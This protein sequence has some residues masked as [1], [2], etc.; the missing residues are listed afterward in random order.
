MGGSIKLSYNPGIINKPEKG[1]V[2]PYAEGFLPVE[3]DISQFVD[4]VKGG[5]AF[6]AQYKDN[7]RKTDNFICS[8]FVAV[9]IDHGLS[10]EDARNNQFLIE[11]ASFIY[12]TPS[13]TDL[14]NRFRIVFITPK[15][16]T[17]V[18]EWKKALQGVGR[19]FGG[20]PSIKDGAR[21]F[22][23]NTAA[24]IWRFNKTLSEGAYQEI[25][26]LAFSKMPSL[27]SGPA[28]SHSRSDAIDL[29]QLVTT[30]FGQVA[31]I[32]DLPRS[33]SIYCP[34]HIDNNP[35]AFITES[36][37][38]IKGVHCSACQTTYW[39]KKSIKNEVS[40][41]DELVKERLT[42]KIETNEIDP[43]GIGE[44]EKETVIRI[45]EK[46]L[47]DLSY[48]KGIT[49][50]K[51]PKGTGKTAALRSLVH[52]IKNLNRSKIL[53]HTPKSILLIGHRQAL[54]REACN[55]LGLTCYLDSLPTHYYG[56][57]LDS[58]GTKLHR[59]MGVPP[60][61]LVI[62]DESEQVF[63][64][65]VSDTI[66]Q[67]SNGLD[68]CFRHLKFYL[69]KAKAI[70]ALDADLDAITITALKALRKNDWE[71]ELRI[72]HN[73]WSVDVDNKRSIKM[74][75]NKGHL[76]K[77]MLSSIERGEKCYIA[78]NSKKM[79]D[80]LE[81]LVK[82]L[83]GS[84]YVKITSENS[85][86]EDIVE[87]VKTISVSAKKVDVILA[88]PSM[89]TGVDIT[90]PDN[91]IVFENVYG[92]FEPLVNT[93][94]DIDQQLARV[95]HPRDVKVFISQRKYYPE[96]DLNVIIENL[97]RAHVSPHAVTFT[98]DGQYKIDYDDP[99]LQIYAE[100]IA[101]RTSSSANIYEN[102]INHKK[103]SGYEIIYVSKNDRQ[104]DIGNQKLTGAKRERIA[105]EVE[106]FIQMPQ[107]SDEQFFGLYSKGLNAK[108]MKRDERILLEK[109]ITERALSIP[110]SRDIIK[111]ILEKR[112]IKKLEAFYF[113]QN[114][115][116]LSSTEHWASNYKVTSELQHQYLPLLRKDLFI[117]VVLVILGLLEEGVLNFRK[118]ITQQDL[119]R[120]AIFCETNRVI[121]GEITG[122]PARMDVKERTLMTLN[123]IL[124]EIGLA[125][126]KMKTQRQ[127]GS[128][129]HV[130][131][132]AP[133]LLARMERLA[134]HYTPITDA[135]VLQEAGCLSEYG[136]PDYKKF[137]SLFEF[138]YP[139]FLE[140]TASVKRV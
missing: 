33:T 91:E 111:E 1:A 40:A 49:L 121:I 34:I 77:E 4:L 20:D 66:M 45:S 126:R 110:L 61:D 129:S 101:Y 81:G 79:I 137:H 29:E 128:V 107:L 92:F 85:Q 60:Y 19:K 13:H 63:S 65:L 87:F 51:S 67:R 83:V 135:T 7:Q 15:T 120:F 46:Y 125:V 21:L 89:G 41:F 57:C 100:V 102:F 130:Y 35:S 116:H 140:K 99:L 53:P 97:G 18:D 136:N 22:Y 115:E 39:T 109:S 123:P 84:R 75:R 113:I 114:D 6:S 78:S 134:K 127:K 132:I 94:T 9:D 124:A 2:V 68:L 139:S 58:L 36:K 17:K 26:S 69:E 10:L 70:I 71:R 108:R 105:L 86:Q 24:E 90:F 73:Q 30:K 131:A 3:V 42:K 8:D 76:V 96:T 106:R 11:N 133:K 27:S 5:F 93:H 72:I 32:K 103:L 43:L 95:R 44:I 64:H 55:K 16:I 119:D 118:R 59:S 54:L 38:G 74:Y 122:R 28:P 25:Q 23:G 52:G 80:D 37:Q 138:N 12:T 50:I 62:I 112:F 48:L 98:D 82:K 88:S 47:P 56:I 31:A 104:S 117:Q 14:E